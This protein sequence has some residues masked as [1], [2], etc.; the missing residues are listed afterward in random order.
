[1]YYAVI[2]GNFMY[3]SATTKY[4]ILGSRFIV[5]RQTIFFAAMRNN[6]PIGLGAGAGATIF[7][8]LARTTKRKS[9]TAVFSVFMGMRQIGLVIGKI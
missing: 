7:G 6:F 5:G 3:F 8:D 1:M 2:L 4:M 9:R